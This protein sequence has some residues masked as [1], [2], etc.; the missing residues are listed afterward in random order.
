MGHYSNATER[1]WE[2]A[3]AEERFVCGLC[4]G[5]AARFFFGLSSRMVKVGFFLNRNNGSK[6]PGY[7]RALKGNLGM[8]LGI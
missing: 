1:C 2:S 4:N 3:L 7:L 6:D 5:N 8:E